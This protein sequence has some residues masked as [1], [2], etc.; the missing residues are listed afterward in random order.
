MLYF[1]V[2]SAVSSMLDNSRMAVVLDLD[3]TLLVANSGSTL[4]SK[5]E[6]AKKNR[7]GAQAAPTPAAFGPSPWQARAAG[8]AGSA[9]WLTWLF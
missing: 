7:C 8:M 1:G 5:I 9:P 6:V 2:A 3:E 4:E